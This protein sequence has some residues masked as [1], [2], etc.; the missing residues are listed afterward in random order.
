MSEIGRGPIAPKDP[1]AKREG[2]YIM[3]NKTICGAP[4]PDGR[5]VC[6]IYE[7]NGR[8]QASAGL[9]GGVTDDVILGL[10]GTTEGLRTLVNSIGVSIKRNEKDKQATFAFQMY[11]HADPYAT[12]TTLKMEIPADG[13]EYVLDWS[14]VEWSDD[15]NVPGQIRFEFD[16]PGCFADV[17]VI[18]Y[19]NDGFKAPPQAES[20]DID[21]ESDSYKEMIAK[22]LIRQGN[23]HRIKKALEK[24]RNG[25]DITVAF[26]GGSIT[27]GAGAV[28]INTKCYAYLA[29]E[30]ICEIAMKGGAADK[31][32]MHY[33]KAGVG[34]TPSELGMLR[35]DTD[36][37]YDG[38][39][40]PD[41][42]VVEFAVN[43]EGDETHGECYD[44]LVRKI[45]NGP[46][47]PAVIL[48]FAVFAN[49]WNLEERLCIVGETYDLPM[50]SARRA[51]VDQ[52]YLSKEE[53]NVLAKSQ[54]FYDLF[55]PTNAGHRIMA[56]AILNMVKNADEA[57][58]EDE[59]DISEIKPPIGGD[60]ENV[61]LIDR[62][63][64][65]GDAVVD[66]GAFTDVD[67]EIQIVER[68]L[69]MTGSPEFADNFMYKPGNEGGAITLEVTC[70]DL[71]VIFKDSASVLVGTADVYV[72]GNKV[73]TLDP[74][75]VGWTHCNPRIVYRS[76]ESAK[77]KVE[78][79]ISEGQED[80]NFTVL[81]F[82]VVE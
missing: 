63:R 17:S 79:K 34:G 6:F 51:V 73:D 75:E 72:D 65:V 41:I 74:H 28:P 59:L 78:V 22:S 57:D 56:D 30:G 12:G 81:G 2:F 38:A 14:Q 69:D 9:V 3:R 15:D 37:L 49:D 11:G 1:T 62:K 61:K 45:Y 13:M 68:N 5:G 19:L 31:E 50:V 20:A 55:H 33:I 76:C 48:M 36:V 42:V 40:T 46:G 35:Y 8:L 18:L 47:K 58:S 82:G 25:E 39:V 54:F 26:I 60:F 64:T 10:M 67:E 7:D 23:N 43:D 4:Q 21:F 24:A 16:D 66:C 71:I 44:S 27:Q 32:K 52:F 70:K 77:H 53:G 80:K 29:Y